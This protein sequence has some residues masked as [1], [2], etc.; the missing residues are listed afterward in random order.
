MKYCIF[1][2]YVYTT[3]IILFLYLRLHYYNNT[4][5]YCIK[6]CSLLNEI[7]HIKYRICSIFTSTIIILFLTVYCMKYCFCTK[8]VSYCRGNTVFCKIVLYTVRDSTL[9]SKGQ[10]FTVLYTVRDSIL[11]YFIQ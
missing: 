9:Y 5:P 8:Y 2:I 11:Q 6:Y 10:Y 4:V 3:V 7:L 1:Y